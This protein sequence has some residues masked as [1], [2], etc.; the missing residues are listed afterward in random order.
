MRAYTKIK[1]FAIKQ[2]PYHVFLFYTVFYVQPPYRHYIYYI[3]NN[4]KFFQTST[5]HEFHILM[6]MQLINT[7]ISLVSEFTEM[8]F[9]FEYDFAFLIMNF[10]IR[11]FKN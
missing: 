11:L 1:V 2:L 7:P 4:N 5:E 9:L 3:L 6:I 10:T 8:Y